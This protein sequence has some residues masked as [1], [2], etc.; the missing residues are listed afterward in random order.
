M[1]LGR[2]V[3]FR[4][5]F[6]SCVMALWSGAVAHGTEEAFGVPGRSEGECSPISFLGPVSAGDPRLPDFLR[7]E[8]PTDRACRS[9]LCESIPAMSLPDGPGTVC[10]GVL[11]FVCVSLVKNRRIW[12]GLCLFVLSNGRLGAARGSRVNISL[13][14]STGPESPTESGFDH[15]LWHQPSCRIPER[16]VGW[17][18]TARCSPGVL[19]PGRKN[20]PLSLDRARWDQGK[21]GLLSRVGWTHEGNRLARVCLVGRGAFRGSVA[22]GCIE[23]ARPPPGRT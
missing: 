9:V 8:G 22:V 15:V 18:V 14:E 10:L 4:T 6:L 21:K 19:A 2:E 12:I 16:W 7:F 1:W 5:V 17:S 20:P 11:G 23:W 13:P 3:R